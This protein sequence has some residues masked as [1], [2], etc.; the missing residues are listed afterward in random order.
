MSDMPA[1]VV[2]E[3]RTDELP[4]DDLPYYDMQETLTGCCD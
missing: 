4:P 2:G 3:L 1:A